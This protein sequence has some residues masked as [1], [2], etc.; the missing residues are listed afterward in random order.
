MKTKFLCAL[1]AALV[2]HALTPSLFAITEGEARIQ[3]IK[4]HPKGPTIKVLVLQDVEGALVEVKGPYNVYDP[5]TGK[6]L[7]TAFSGSSYYMHP[8]TDGIKWGSEF[9]GVFQVLIVPDNAKTTFL[10]QGVEYH[11]MLYC[12]QADGTIGYVNELTIDDYADSLVACITQEKVLDK[13]AFAAL[14]IAARAD[15][16]YK[17]KH[18]ASKFWHVKG[19]LVNYIGAACTRTDRPF[20]DAMKETQ[21]MV[22]DLNQQI[23]WFNNN[24]VPITEIQQQ[25]ID[26][27]TA[28]AILRSYFPDSSISISKS[29]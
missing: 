14:A 28:K 17:I 9:P 21:G 8:T 3:L 23:G 22:L 15:A 19:S 5:N 13:E 10:L 29:E 25:A 12:Y 4:H 6:K 26:G 20:L 11:G 16:L 27:K 1:C 18:G 7:E 24:P 2:A